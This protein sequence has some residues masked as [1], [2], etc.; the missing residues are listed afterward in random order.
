[1]IKSSGKGLCCRWRPKKGLCI[2]C[3][4]DEHA[5][6]C[7]ENYEKVDMRESTE[8]T[9]ISTTTNRKIKTIESYRKKKNLCIMCGRDIHK[10]I[11]LADYLKSDMRP[12]EDK[13]KNPRTVKTPKEQIKTSS[14]K[15]AEKN[16]I[17]NEIGID[18]NAKFEPPFNREYI[19]LDVKE[20]DKGFRI[21]YSA[22]NYL[23][24]RFEDY[25]L[26]IYGE[27]EKYFKYD[28][29]F[30]IE[31]D[32]NIFLVKNL[33][34]NGEQRYISNSSLYLSYHEFY[35]NY[36]NIIKISNIQFDPDDEVNSS[37]LNKIMKEVKFK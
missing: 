30:K 24:K 31:K 26:C 28:D 9:K 36:C 32:T 15:V 17:K 33:E 12:P 4:L 27:I 6:N 2:R 1:M 35:I 23:S 7:E 18:I 19:L 3:G 13:I 21:D 11:C 20:S 25:I 16:K 22:I 10:G 37:N 8:P 5:G 29:I 14:Q 34:K